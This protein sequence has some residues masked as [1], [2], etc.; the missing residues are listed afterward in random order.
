[1][2]LPDGVDGVLWKAV[3]GLPELLAVLAKGLCGIERAD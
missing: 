3:I 1:M 2:R